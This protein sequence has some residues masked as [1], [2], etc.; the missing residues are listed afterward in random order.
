MEFLDIN[1]TKDSN[2]L[3]N[4]AIYSP[5]YW[6]I[7]KKTILFSDAKIPYKKICE[8]RKHDLFMNSILKNGKMRVENETKTGA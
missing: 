8:T 2:L 7:L 6:R 3:L 1:L 5:F 4:D